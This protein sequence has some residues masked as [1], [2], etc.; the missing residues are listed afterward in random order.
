[1]IREDGH[2]RRRGGIGAIVIGLPGLAFWAVFGGKV[3]ATA[4]APLF[5]LSLLFATVGVWLVSQKVKPRVRIVI[6][7]AGLTVVHGG[8]PKPSVEIG[9]GDLTLV[10]L[11]GRDA[12]ARIQFHTAPGAPVYEVM[13]RPLDH[14][15]PEIIRLISI[16][17]QMQ[18]MRLEQ[19]I[20]A[21][22]GAATGRWHRRGGAG[23]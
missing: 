1:M 13:T 4:A 3:F 9:W 14:N 15:A 23:L 18:G 12:T 5:I 11:Q 7:D 19:D 10:T 8:L 22:L 21:V 20:S 6:R 16:R 2:A 17:L